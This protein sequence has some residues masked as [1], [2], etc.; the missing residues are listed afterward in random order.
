VVRLVSVP[1]SGKLWQAQ[2]DIASRDLFYGPGGKQEE[3]HGTF[4]FVK[5][6]LNGTNPK[7]VVKDGQQVIWGVKMGDEARPETVAA[8]ILWA[9]GYFAD[10]DYFASLIHVR[11]LPLR[12]HRGKQFVGPDGSLRNVRLKRYSQD[13]ERLAGNWEWGKNPFTGTREL[14][15]LR[16]M[17]ALINNWDVTD[18]NTAIHERTHPAGVV[19]RYYLIGDLGSS[20][21]SPKLTWPMRKARGNLEVYRRSKFIEKAMPNYVDFQAP[22]GA[23]LFFLGT[24]REYFNK[25]RTRWI[26]RHIPRTDVRWIGQILAELKADQIRDAFRAAG[27]T[28]PEVESFASTVENRIRALNEL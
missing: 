11:G 16:A 2:F 7:I 10:K 28:A 14:N 5:E 17:M 26:G 8:R 20:F 18:E 9:V 24:P 15:G 1:D 22:A 6:D 21:G 19:E 3:P 4:T 12:L 27:Y 13:D 25:R 23:S